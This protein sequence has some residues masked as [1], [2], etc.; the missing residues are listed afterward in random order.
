MLLDAGIAAVER[1]LLPDLLTRRAVRRLCA[2]RLAE[3]RHEAGPLRDRQGQFLATMRHGP[4]APLPEKANEQHYEVA[5]EFFQAVLGPRLKY[6]CCYWDEE[7]GSLADAE[8]RALELTCEQAELRDGQEVLELG[9]G[10]GS[11]SLWMAEQYPQS[12]I[13]AMSNSS[14]QREF[15]EA[16]AYERGLAN[17]KVI[18]ADINRFDPLRWGLGGGRF[19]R[20]VS[21]EMFE[22]L[23]N[24]ELLFERIAGWLHHEGRLFMHIFCHR[25][26]AYPFETTGSANWMGRYFFTGGMMPCADLPH[27]FARHLCVEQEWA[28]N[29]RH[30]QRTAEA[31]LENLD[32]RRGE[33]MERLATTYG[34]REARR[35]Y[36][37]WRV[38]FLAVAELFGYRQGEEWRVGHYLL[39]RTSAER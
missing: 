7:T 29:G 12:R 34:S 31:W 21:V 17:L 32:A 6:S 24:Y 27:R 8:T 37:R 38:F 14:A 15:I 4:L 18:T 10:W 16:R 33:V 25:Q 20:V 35:W 39:Q 26:F 28:W 9:C 30:Y 11:L 1:G 2:Q 13:T 19:D 36:H 5:P 23:R 3:L 22:H